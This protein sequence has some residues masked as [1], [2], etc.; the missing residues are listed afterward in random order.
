MAQKI[1]N[2]KEV[3]PHFKQNKFN[4]VYFFYG[5]DTFAFNKII[6]MFEKAFET[7][8]KSEFDVKTF[9]GSNQN[10]SDIADFVFSF[11]FGSEKKLAIVREYDKLK[12]P[13]IIPS[14]VSSPSDFTVLV[15]FY[16]EDI[17]KFETKFLKSLIDNNW[18]FE[19]GELKG[20][21]LINWMKR[22]AIERKK[23]ISDEDAQFL[24]S[25]TGEN[26]SLIEQQL[27]K[28]IT[29]LGDKT[30]I[31]YQIIKEHVV[32]TRTFTVFDLYAAIG[33]GD[34][35]RA[36][37]VAFNLLETDEII[38]IIGGLNKYFSGL[39]QIPEME[40]ANINQFEK[41]RVTGTNTYY[42]KDYVAASNRFSK[43][44]LI[45]IAKALLEA[46]LSI[47]SSV[48]EKL[49]MSTLLTKIFSEE[50]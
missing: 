20:G 2:I 42:Y 40:A 49:V 31:N 39:L 4:P 13:K 24:I 5:N 35:S 3:L 7:I 29:F 41:A 47:K 19:A 37:K 23:I 43:E 36:F 10:E 50:F 38:A 6:K 25:L 30:D 17:K 34:K 27:E 45:S 9:H 18:I 33:K 32:E 21:E 44:R 8:A 15:I 12:N 1:P 28:M 48:D 14:I 22:F 16:E 11:P 26:R 46:D